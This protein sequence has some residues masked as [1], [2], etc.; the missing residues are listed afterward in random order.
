MGCTCSSEKQTKTN[1]L[2]RSASFNELRPELPESIITNLLKKTKFSRQDIL[3]WWEGFLTDCPS[4]LLDKKKF[5]EVY[6]Y[7]Y[8]NGKAKNFCTHVFRTFNPDKR[9][10]AIDFERFMCAIDITQNGSS[11]EKLEWA[12]TMYDIN[13]DDRI[14]KTEMSKVVESMFD[15]LGKNKKGLNNPRKHVDDIFLRIDTNHDNYVTK[16]E[17]LTGCKSDDNIR[18]ILAPNY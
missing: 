16:D 3:D 11:D 13:G 10:R 8:P 7:R 4:G 14:S 9:N 5:I 18:T 15:L 17:F 6:E 2:V 1:Q 12:F